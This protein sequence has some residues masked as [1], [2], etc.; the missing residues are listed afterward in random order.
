MENN[1]PRGPGPHAARLKAENLAAAVPEPDSP[2][3]A[4]HDGDE[5][6][7][8]R[9]GVVEN[10]IAEGYAPE[11]F[12][13]VDFSIVP[14]GRTFHLFHIAHVRQSSYNDPGHTTWIGH[15]TTDDFDTWVTLP[16]CLH[17][18]PMNHYEASHVWAPFVLPVEESHLMF[19]TGV[20]PETSQTL[21]VAEAV[22]AELKLW[23]RTEH[24]PII[25]VTG[26]D[27][28]WRNFHGHSRNA[29]DPHVVRLK[30]HYLLAYTAMHQDRCGAV[31]GLVSRDLE[32]WEDIGPLLYR[33]AKGAKG[34][35]ES[36]NIQPM[37][38][39]QW[40]L[41]PSLEPGL[42]YY[43]SD[44]PYGW[45][46]ARPT[47]IECENA[48]REKIYALEVIDRD[49]ESMEWLVAYFDSPGYRLRFG[50]LTCAQ[51]PWVIRQAESPSDIE[52]WLK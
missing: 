29:R 2:I 37:P 40:A 20:S 16:P 49:D 32:H 28:H 31:G 44:S 9:A 42:A 23:Q 17:T 11:G 18:N 47:P 21:C 14:V 19:Y 33:P 38:D 36:V 3:A 10:C 12:G 50:T 30:D 22:D 15:A 26:F 13:V 1:Q 35:P 45:H 43:L 34:L 6:R 48:N 52:R 41:I 25:P 27:W 51:H 8:A 46:D 5:V 39:G 4:L 24:N 7:S